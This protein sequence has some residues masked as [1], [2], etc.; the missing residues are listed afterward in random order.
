ARA[1]EGA[2]PLAGRNDREQLPSGLQLWHF[3]G[4]PK[5]GKRHPAWRLDELGKL[6]RAAGQKTVTVDTLWRLPHLNRTVA[7]VFLPPGTPLSTEAHVDAAAAAAML[8]GL[9][10][11]GMRFISKPAPA[12]LHWTGSALWLADPLLLEHRP[13]TADSSERLQDMQLL[14]TTLA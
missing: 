1:T 8:A 4:L 11:A 6:L 9:H 12:D 5:W 10:Q 2:T 7:R 14:S 13:G 3:A